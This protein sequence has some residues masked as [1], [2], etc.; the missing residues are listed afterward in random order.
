MTFVTKQYFLNFYRMATTE[1]P[2][3]D[4]LQ[5]VKEESSGTFTNPWFV[6]TLD[7]FLYYCCPECN[8]KCQFHDEFHHHALISHPMVS[9]FEYLLNF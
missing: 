9:L 3:M 1:L 7:D 5:N 6:Q 8:Y 2:D 4:F